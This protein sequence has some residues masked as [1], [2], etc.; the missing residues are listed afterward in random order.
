MVAYANNFLCF[1]AGMD[2][3]YLLGLQLS[4][5]PI[6]FLFCLLSTLCGY[7]LPLWG[8]ISCQ[9][10]PSMHQYGGRMHSCQGDRKT[11]LE[12]A[13]AIWL[14]T[15]ALGCPLHTS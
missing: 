9:D 14:A 15:C 12:I 1:V 7:P 3:L 13:I 10:N 5:M 8:N 6:N 2:T 4:L 11:K